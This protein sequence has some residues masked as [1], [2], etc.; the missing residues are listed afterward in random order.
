MVNG[1]HTKKGNMKKATYKKAGKWVSQTWKDVPFSSI[2]S[3]FIEAGII[4]PLANNKNYNTSSND[5]KQ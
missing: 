1:L 2:K 5:T 4:I 3:V